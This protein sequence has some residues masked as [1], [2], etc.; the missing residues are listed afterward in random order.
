MA[1][2][3]REEAQG[4]GSDSFLDVV[5]NIVGILI[6][7]VMVVGIR[8]KHAPA[9]SAA[10][11]W[12][13]AQ[14]QAEVERLQSQADSLDRDVRKTQAQIESLAAATEGQLRSRSTLAYLIAEHERELAGTRKALDEKSQHA[15]DLRRARAKADLDL[16]RV[17][18]EAGEAGA[19]AEKAKKPIQIQSRPT[20]ISH[21]VFGN[22]VHFRLLGGR[23]TYVPIDELVELCTQDLDGKTHRLRDHEEFSGTM[24]PL[25]GFRADYLVRRFVTPGGY[26][27]GFFGVELSPITEG[28]GESVADALQ[29]KSD[30]RWRLSNFSRG[31]TTVTLWTYPDSFT[32]YSIVKEE[33][34]RLGFAVAARPME[35]GVLIGGSNEGSHSSAQ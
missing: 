17:Q 25:H 5:T 23:I 26:G 16:A 21:T 3:I 35:E 14:A 9:N 22:E 2:F 27:V 4:V 6:I 30:F 19:I 31:R 18:R 10:P 29:E 8:V 28:L 11:A 33:L 13:E 34:Y 7:L 24:G 12:D 32:D 1:R 20:P 15:F